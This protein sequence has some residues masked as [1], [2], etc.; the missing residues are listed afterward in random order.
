MGRISLSGVNDNK[1]WGWLRCWFCNAGSFLG[2]NSYCVLRIACCVLRNGER[3]GN[4]K[5]VKRHYA[6]RKFA[7][8]VSYVKR[9]VK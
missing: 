7:G 9:A 8:K 6:L 1:E 4:A 2:K 5:M 3:E